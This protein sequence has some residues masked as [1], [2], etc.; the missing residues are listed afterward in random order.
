M[1]KLPIIASVHGWA[2]SEDESLGTMSDTLVRSE[3][4]AEAS[5][6]HA[7]SGARNPERAHAATNIAQTHQQTLII[8]EYSTPD[9][10]NRDLADNAV[11]QRCSQWVE[12]STV[13]RSLPDRCGSWPELLDTAAA[14]APTGAT[15][16]AVARLIPANAT[17]SALGAG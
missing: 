11:A 2:L 4:T 12:S 14:Q 8:T 15:S 13:V 6:D 3:V 5:D 7:S 1:Q 17:K 10:D 9:P 16:P